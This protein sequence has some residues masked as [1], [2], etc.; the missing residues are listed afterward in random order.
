MCGFGLRRVLCGVATVCIYIGFFVSLSIR[1]INYVFS[2]RQTKHFGTYNFR[3]WLLTKCVS[4]V[5]GWQFALECVN[6]IV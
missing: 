4:A 3:V 1:S 2:I 6:R 5:Q